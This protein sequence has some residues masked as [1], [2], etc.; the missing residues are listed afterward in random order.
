MPENF[1]VFTSSPQCSPL[2]IVARFSARAAAAAHA[3]TLPPH[4]ESPLKYAV[5]TNAVLSQL[6]CPVSDSASFESSSTHAE[7]T[8][9][10]SDPTLIS[11][12][13][14]LSCSCQRL[15]AP[16][17][18]LDGSDSQSGFRSSASPDIVS[19]WNAFM[20]ATETFPPEAIRSVISLEIRLAR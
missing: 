4:V 10:G 7:N 15:P 6:G 11:M 1:F 12:F 18:V 17:N 2:A 8:D 13:Q 5:R 19:S 3:L 9:A 14:L 16:L 20:S